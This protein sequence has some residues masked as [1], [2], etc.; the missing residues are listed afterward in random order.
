MKQVVPDLPEFDE[1]Q[2]Q[3]CREVKRINVSAAFFLSIE[4]QQ[5]GY[6]VYRTFKAAYGDSLS[7]NVPGTIPITR[8]NDFLSDTRIIG[9]GVVVGQGNWEEKLEANKQAYALEFV[10][11]ARFT[12]AFPTTMT[13][14]QFVAKLIQN[15]GVTLTT[16]ERDQLISTLGATPADASRRAQVLR[17]VAENQQL[18]QAEL[19]RAFVL[20]EYFGYLRRNPDAAPEATLNYAGWKFWLDKLNEF[21][22]NYVEAEMVKA[23]ISSDEYRKRFGQ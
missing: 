14:D 8:F 3:Q 21:S 7:L 20:M 1:Y 2:Y 10:Q 9:D 23:F 12:T 11:R 15:A 5:T 18:R 16:G 17:S 6:L 19:N 13:A 22:G 4:F